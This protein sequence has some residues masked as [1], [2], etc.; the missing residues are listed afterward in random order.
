MFAGSIPEPMSDDELAAIDRVLLEV[1][2]ERVY[3]ASYLPVTD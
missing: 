2:V 1:T 3:G